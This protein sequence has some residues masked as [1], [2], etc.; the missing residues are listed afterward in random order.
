MFET[1]ATQGKKKKA[2]AGSTLAIAGA[3]IASV[4]LLGFLGQRQYQRLTTAEAWVAN[5]AIN[6]GELVQPEQVAKGRVKELFAVGAIDDSK[7]IIGRRLNVKKEAGA[8]F[9]AQDFVQDTQPRLA[10]SVPDG[11]VIYTLPVDKQQTNYLT[12]LRSGDRF[13]VLLTESSG[14]VGALATDVMLVGMMRDQRPS[15]EPQGRSAITALTQKSGADDKPAGDLALL[16]IDP[17]FVF[18]LA[19]AYS[20]AGKLSFVVHNAKDV[21]SGR[22]LSVLPGSTTRKVEVYSG[23]LKKQV[24]VKR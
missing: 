11:R 14:R 9:R 17:R 16:A 20:T 12:Q 21:E 4:A 3:V 19:A 23:L 15:A 2:Y 10:T 7:S 22:R 8:V 13:D 1:R 18:G 24:E 6:P 5:A